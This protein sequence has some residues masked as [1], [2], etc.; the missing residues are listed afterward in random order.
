MQADIVIIGAL[1]AAAYRLRSARAG[2]PDV[3]EE[4]EEP[5]SEVTIERYIRMVAG[6]REVCW[7]T[8]TSERVDPAHCADLGLE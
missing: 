1:L 6:D 8:W 5:A 3:G 4:L 2:A 7:D